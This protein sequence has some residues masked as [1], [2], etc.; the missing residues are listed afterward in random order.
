MSDMVINK[1]N[2]CATCRPI[3]AFGLATLMACSNPGEEVLQ[4]LEKWQSAQLKS[5]SYVI[6]RVCFCSTDYV[7]P[8]RVTVEG[9]DVTVEYVDSSQPVSEEVL[10]SWFL[11]PMEKVFKNI[12][13][14]IADG[15]DRVDMDFDARYGYPTTV[16]FDYIADAIDDELRITISDFRVIDDGR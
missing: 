16:D 9:N 8:F 12:H 5:Y 6:R 1:Q 4:N 3:L 7:G 13:E 2:I 11:G 14:A 15:I 10:K